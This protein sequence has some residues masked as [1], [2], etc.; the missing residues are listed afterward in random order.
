MW[1]EEFAPIVENI[2]FPVTGAAA[3]QGQ[4]GATASTHANGPAASWRSNNFTARIRHRNSRMIPSAPACCSSTD[5][6]KL[7]FA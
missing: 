3:T 6:G 5:Y 4:T 1:A 2:L 7:I